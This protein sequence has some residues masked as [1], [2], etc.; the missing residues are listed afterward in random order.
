[1]KAMKVS[2]YKAR[3]AYA[4]GMATVVWPALAHATIGGGTMPWDPTLVKLQDDMQG[5]VAHTIVT[6]AVIGTGLMWGVSEHGT[7]IRKV[8]GVAFGGALALG[9]ATFM[10]AAF[11]A[12]ALF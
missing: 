11:G 3:L 12:G 7:G 4:F 10:N 9:A 6:A 2:K 8:S 5:T 1:M